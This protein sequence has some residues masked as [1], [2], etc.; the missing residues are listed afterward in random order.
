[1]AAKPIVTQS[2]IAKSWAFPSHGEPRLAG[3]SGAQPDDGG[4]GDQ[5]GQADGVC[6][7]SH[8]STPGF[9][10]PRA[11]CCHHASGDRVRLLSCA[12]GIQ[13]EALPYLSMAVE[14]VSYSF[15]RLGMG[16]A[17][18]FDKALDDDVTGVIVVPG[19]LA[20]L[21]ARFKR[22]AKAKVPVVCLLTEAP[23]SEKLATVA[24]NAHSCGALAG[25]ILSRSLA[26]E[27]SRD[28]H[29]H[30]RPESHRSRA[31]SR[32]VY[33]CSHGGSP[34]HHHPRSD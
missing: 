6:T 9:E 29:L 25:E 7:Q 33:E 16:E 18:A 11:H 15:S 20:H 23:A 17:A 32:L 21:K 3:P 5:D 24:V 13:D 22:A 30:R 14:V 27:S 34:R 28:C 10:S 31:E 1:M 19:D 4:V 8:G 2:S 26:S 12:T